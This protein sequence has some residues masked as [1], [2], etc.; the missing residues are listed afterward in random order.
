[1]LDIKYMRRIGPI[2]TA[3]HIAKRIGL[4]DILKYEEARYEKWMTLSA[5]EYPQEL[6]KW[7]YEFTGKRLNLDAPK[8]F[9]EKLQWL[10]LYDATPL[11][12]KLADKYLVRNWLSDKVGSEHL[13]PL[14]GV[15]DSF[16]E[17]DFEQ[18]PP[19]FA[20]KAN[21]GSGWNI[22]VTDK[23]KLDKAAAKAKFDKWLSLNFAFVSGLELHY[24]DIS[25]KIIAEQFIE[26][27]KGLIDYRFYC[28]HGEPVQVWVD[29][30]SGTRNHR[31]EIYDMEWNKLPLKCTWPSGDGLL[32]EKPSTF[33][34]MKTY[35]KLLSKD[36]K[37]VRV[38]FFEVNQVLYMGEM[39][40]IP[41][42]GIGDFSPS[43]W[44]IILGEYL[45]I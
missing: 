31:R 20:L 7:Y 11:K 14:L 27:T 44:D 38:D 18:L 17:I 25:P 21:H 26:N 28:F 8:S 23:T 24:K 12:T 36:F 32:D 19:K 1:M 33:S 37:F 22:I 35:A 41:M 5:E 42:G 30:Y 45:N 29:I 40:F 9:N 2:R 10:K 39:T 3:N 13:I 4:T 34:L 16:D 43:K 15:W 6:A